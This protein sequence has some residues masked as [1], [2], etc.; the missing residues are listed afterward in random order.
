[1]QCRYPNRE[2]HAL[3]RC[4]Q[5]ARGGRRRRCGF[6]LVEL[7]VVIG[8]IALLVSI[9]LPALGRARQSAQTVSCLSGFRQIGAAL[10][11]YVIDYKGWLPGPSWNGQSPRFSIYGSENLAWYLARYCNAPRQSVSGS[12]T[13][14]N[15]LFRCAALTDEEVKDGTTSVVVIQLEGNH[16]VSGKLTNDTNGH[17]PFGY[18]KNDLGVTAEGPM[19]MS[20]MRRTSE[21]IVMYETDLR[22]FSSQPGWPVRPQPVHGKSGDLARRNHLFFDGH[23]ETVQEKM[24][25]QLSPMN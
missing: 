15:P 9:L 4:S 24:I 23:A 1:M 11:L 21:T 18:P 19:P 6:T 16:D 25:R 10:Q 12:T 3:S 7:L 17:R 8:I 20:Q 5:S 14:I 2:V 22:C 13:V